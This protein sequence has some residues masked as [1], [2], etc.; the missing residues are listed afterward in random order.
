MNYHIFITK[1]D[2]VSGMGIKLVTGTKSGTKY[3]SNFD[4]FDKYANIV[5][6]KGFKRPF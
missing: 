3:I 1:F 6:R 5:T 4:N 2:L